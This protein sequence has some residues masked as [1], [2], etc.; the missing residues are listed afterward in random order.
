VVRQAGGSGDGALRFI[1]EQTKPNTGI[2]IESTE[3]AVATKMLRLGAGTAIMSSTNAL[4]NWPTAALTHGGFAIVN[5]N[6]TPYLIT[7]APHTTTW[8]ATNALGGGGSGTPGGADSQVQYNSGGSFAGHG[9]FTFHDTNAMPVVTMTNNVMIGSNSIVINDG[10]HKWLQNLMVGGGNYYTH[11]PIIGGT[12]G[13][14]IVGGDSHLLTNITRC[15]VFGQS[16]RLGPPP[17]GT[18]MDSGFV[19]GQ[20]FVVTNNGFFYNPGGVTAYSLS[21][22]FVRFY[23]P[24][25][26]G[27]DLAA[28][29]VYFNNPQAGAMAPLASVTNGVFNGDGKGLTNVGYTI[30][31]GNAVSLSPAD[32]ITYYIGGDFGTSLADATFYTNAYVLIPVAG[33]ISRVVYKSRNVIASTEAVEHYIRVNDTTDVGQWTAT[34]GQTVTNSLVTGISQA[35]AAGDRIAMKIV[36]PTWVT[37]PTGQKWYAVVYIE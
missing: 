6:A 25:G 34:Y 35:V 7:S 1:G 31:V 11:L 13:S 22:N 9:A 30:T 17:G 37:N 10:A 16:H 24:T 14:S 2:D 27:I 3:S 26:G 5:S 29:A 8:A 32:G 36:C 33:T 19:F 21:N 28:P 15:F 18:S 4:A 23:L 20:T 12:A